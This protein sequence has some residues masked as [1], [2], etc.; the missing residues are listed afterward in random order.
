MKL[1]IGLSTCPNDTFAFHALMSRAVGWRGFEFEFAL[2]D[3]EE[4]NERMLGG[5][6]DASKVSFHAALGAGARWVVLEAGAALGFGVG[7]VLLAPARTAATRRVLAPGRHTTA[8]LLWRLFHA[9]DGEP[10]HVVF[11]AIVPALERGDARL[12]V[13]IHEARFTWREHGLALVEDLGERW[14]RA[15][16]APLPLGGIAARA[17]LGADALERL[18]ACVRDSIEWGL[19]HRGECLPTMRA[20]AQESTDGVLWQHVELYVNA[21]TLELG[22]LGRRG[23]DALARLAAAAGIGSG[24]AFAIAAPPPDALPRVFHV[25]LP[26]D[27]EPLLAGARARYAPAAFAREGFVHLSRA[28]QLDATLERHYA[29]TERF[30]S[31]LALLELDLARCGAALRFEASRGGVAFPHLYR[32][33]ERADVLRTWALGRDASGRWRAPLLPRDPRGDQPQAARYF[34][35]AVGAAEAVP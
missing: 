28:G 2:A 21:Q 7:P 24:A 6:L 3:V 15:T 30:S 33:I 19:A 9:A 14:E 16:G 5:A 4:L 12:G 18:A 25:A 17:D 32:E 31:G 13:C 35:A 27:V 29:E 8:A 23:L 26:A 22:E 10:E 1:R 11:S 20:H 34:G